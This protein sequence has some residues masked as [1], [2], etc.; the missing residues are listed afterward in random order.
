MDKMLRAWC[1]AG[2]LLAATTG[3]LAAEP[4]AEFEPTA[5]NL[6]VVLRE[7]PGANKPDDALKPFG[8]ISADL[9]DGRHIEFEASWYQYL[10]D[11]HLRIVFDGDERIESALPGDLKRLHLSPEQ[12]IAR[13]VE[14]LRRRYGA[15]VAEPWVGGMM[16]VHGN[17]PEFDSSYFLDRAFW[18]EQ[19]RRSPQGLVVGVPDRGGLVFARADDEDAVANLRFG[20]AALYAS[21]DRTHI[22][23]GL[24]LFKNGRWSVYQ[25]PQAVDDEA[26]ASQ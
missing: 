20:A 5:G 18:V 11:M 21:H 23:S 13:A 3:V 26:H 17:A 15:P 4:A 12:A 16:Q 14:N 25:P 10:G 2:V 9:P 24:Y 8:T 1:G 22:S 7:S 19:L 6:L